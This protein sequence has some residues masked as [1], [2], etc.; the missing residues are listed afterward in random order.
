MLRRMDCMSGGPAKEETDT[1]QEP[2]HVA[3]CGRTALPHIAMPY[4]R[5]KVSVGRT[6]HYL[7]LNTTLTHKAYAPPLRRLLRNV[8]LPFLASGGHGRGHRPA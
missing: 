3:V 4:L 6:G 8:H 1:N 7:Y 2:T 5:K